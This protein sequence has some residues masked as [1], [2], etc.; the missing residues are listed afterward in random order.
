MPHSPLYIIGDWPSINGRRRLSLERS[1]TLARQ[2]IFQSLVCLTSY[3]KPAYWQLSF[4][5]PLIVFTCLL[6]LRLIRSLHKKLWRYG[7][8]NVLIDWLID[9]T[10]YFIYLFYFTFYFIM[11]KQ[12]TTNARLKQLRKYIETKTCCNKWKTLQKKEYTY[13]IIALVRDTN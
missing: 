8:I 7:Y 10:T 1:A 9:Y 3:E 11:S 4:L 13:I 2:R 12:I 6:A 5:D